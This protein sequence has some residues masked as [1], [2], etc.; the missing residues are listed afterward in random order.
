MNDNPTGRV[1]AANAHPSYAW[2]QTLL[3]IA[4]GTSLSEPFHEAMSHPAYP[5][6]N[7]YDPRWIFANAMGPIPTWQVEEIAPQMQFEPGQRVLDLGCGGALTSIF[8]ARE[9]GV[10]VVAA[11]LWIDPE[12][13]AARIAEAGC[14]ALVAPVRAE[15]RRLPFELGSFDAVVSFD[16]YHYFGTDIRYLSY[17]VQ[18]VR[19][20]GRIGIVS[21]GNTVDPDEVGA[22]ALPSDLAERYGADWYTFRSADWWGRHWSRTL[23]V[24]V[25]VAAM[26]E[27]GR[28]TWLRHGKAAEAWSAE[29]LKHLINR[30]MMD[31]EAGQTLGFCKVVARRN[32]RPT[33]NFG[34][35]EYETRIA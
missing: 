29:A 31:S 2:A 34:F 5:R 32:D 15:A 18:F 4:P 28:A 33:L 20:G 30:D 8:L 12:A 23:C 14:E 10:E 3:P 7:A 27:G 24:D 16:A 17:L 19:P 1:D 25:E 26:V 35:G 6:S 21:P 11:D 9:Y 13:N 22:V